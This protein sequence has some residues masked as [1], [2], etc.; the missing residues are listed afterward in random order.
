MKHYLYH[1][2]PHDMKGG[3]LYPLNELR[4]IHPE[5][6]AEKFGKY[7]GREEITRLVLP[8]L[9]CLWN[10]VLHFTAIHPKIIKSALIAAGDMRKPKVRCYEVDPELLD[11]ENTIVFLYKESNLFDSMNSDN[12]VPYDPSE[13]GN[14]S[15]LPQVTLDYFKDS[16][17]KYGKEPMWLHRVPHILYKGSLNIDGLSIVEV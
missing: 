2:V 15:D 17:E 16:Y 8:V 13:I 14:Y 6:Y 5:L 3:T 11:P 12:V 4:S 7:A 9:G 10:D 1:W